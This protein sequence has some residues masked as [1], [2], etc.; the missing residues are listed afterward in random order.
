MIA[1]LRG[2]VLS[3]EASGVIVEAGGV[4]YAV[5]V[6]VRVLS[7]LKEG[8]ETRLWIHHHLREDAS[9][10]FGF[11]ERSDKRLF[12]KLLSVSGV[13]P[14]VAL[15]LLSLRGASQLEGI[16][17]AGRVAELTAQPGVGKKTAERIVLE[18][19]GGLGTE[20]AGTAGG[21]LETALT[22]LGYKP[23][24]ARS[25]LEGVDVSLPQAERLLLALQKL[26]R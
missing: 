22:E 4:G 6:P 3:L 9:L 17:T 25:A 10:L 23:A 16:I 13:G 7:T 14:K 21:E 15:S 12:V 26:A 5:Q 11:A 24:D 1:H 19:G 8:S 2:Q 18:L 20:K